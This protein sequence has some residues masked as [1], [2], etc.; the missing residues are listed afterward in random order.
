M[1]IIDLHQDIRLH[2]QK[3]YPYPHPDHVQ[4][5]FTMMEEQDVKI[6]LASGFPWPNDE[7][8]FD[9]AIHD[10]IIDDFKYYQNFVK[11]NKNWSL[12]LSQ[13]ALI[14]LMKKEDK[15]GLILH[16]EG[17]NA[18]SG[19][20]EDWHMM[21][22]LHAMGLRS[23]GIVWNFANNLGGGANDKNEGLTVLG[24]QFISWCQDKHIIIDFAHMNEKTFFDTADMISQPIVISHGNARALS[25]HQRNYSDEEIIRMAKSGGVMGLF[26]SP[27]Y[28]KLKGTVTVRDVVLHIN[29]IRD[30]VGIDHV[31]IGSD[32]G[33]ITS[34]TFI[35]N[36]SSVSDLPNLLEAL[37]KEGYSSEDIEKITW[38]NA[39]RVLLEILE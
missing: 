26:F 34:D 14:D 23:V 29:Y 11:K 36:L 3:R 20:N 13:K 16:I 6:V 38:K 27:R 25:D 31:A 8:H 9:P 33:G 2:I 21:D 35:E 5:S 12:V 22:R 19:S 15:R 32:F 10:L 28:I 30:L 18:F 17:L 1:P 7:K 39:Q 4:T 37:Q 24:R